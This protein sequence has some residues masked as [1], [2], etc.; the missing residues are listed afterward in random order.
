MDTK[1]VHIVSSSF[2]LG[3]R[4]LIRHQPEKALRYFK[5]A[6]DAC[7]TSRRTDLAK[8]L[9]WLSMT[10]F[11]LGRDGI[12]IKSLLNA[13]RL[14]PRGFIRGFYDHKVNG[15]GMPRAACADDDDFRAFSSIHLARY[16]ATV[17]GAQFT[18]KAEAEMVLTMIAKVWV[19]WTRSG[20]FQAGSCIEKLQAFKSVEI[21]YPKKGRDT[22]SAN[23]VRQLPVNFRT[24]N[25][26]SPGDRCFCGS[27]LPYARC[28]GRVRIPFEAPD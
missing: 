15:Y 2:R 25:K 28:C 11:R 4:S 13:R 27:G 1:P 12:A 6:V 5:D 22:T 20:H 16:L 18:S 21:V 19:V 8:L 14:Q 9:Y 10:L 3:R 23:Q 7:P 24:G 17:P 26:I